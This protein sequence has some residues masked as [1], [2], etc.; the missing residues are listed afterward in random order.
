MSPACWRP[1]W[2]DLPRLGPPAG[3]SVL[4]WEPGLRLAPPCPPAAELAVTVPSLAS[5]QNW[6]G[7]LWFPHPGLLLGAMPGGAG[8]ALDA[9]LR[10]R[11]GVAPSVSGPPGARRGPAPG[12]SV[13]RGFPC[14][15]INQHW[16]VST[17]TECVSVAGL[18][19]TW[20]SENGPRAAL[21]ASPASPSGS[22][23]SYLCC[24]LLGHCF[25]HTLWCLGSIP[26]GPCRCGRPASGGADSRR[27]W[28]LT[29]P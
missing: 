23:W 17:R 7:C 14:P 19:S 27:P 21:E 10:C 8:S 20:A 22:P 24:P 6:F 5:A 18:G 29:W 2:T 26:W 11:P 3:A 13:E 12:A 16:C 9:A 28:R 25:A 4:R 1:D 15:R